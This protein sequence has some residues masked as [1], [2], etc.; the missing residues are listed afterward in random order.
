[1]AELNTI[2]D[3][4]NYVEGRNDG[5]EMLLSFAKNIKDGD[6]KVRFELLYAYAQGAK[7]EVKE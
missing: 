4:Q 7:I 5:I 3:C 2:E 1:M 6:G